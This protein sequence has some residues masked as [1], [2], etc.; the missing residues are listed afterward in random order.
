MTDDDG[1]PS[2]IALQYRDY[3]DEILVDE[4]Q[5]TNRVQEAIISCIKRGEEHNGNLFMVG[6]VKQSIYKFRQAEPEL[7]I[8][9]YKRFN[10]PEIASGEV[11]DLSKNFRS[12]KEVLDNTNFIFSH[13]M[14]EVVGEIEYN[15]EAKLYYGA[16][17]DSQ[18]T[19]LE[20][21][22]IVQDSFEV[23]DNNLI[24]AKAIV[25]KVQYILDNKRVFDRKRKV[26][27]QQ[28]SKIS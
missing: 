14:D 4:Y 9:K 10:D 16:D 27:D 13:M 1:N 6:D 26:I 17:Y 3:F 7:F 5:D 20:M 8:E 22:I 11:I 2:E 28:L 12:R 24:E 15:D 19:P 18:H 21:D 23:E 25:D